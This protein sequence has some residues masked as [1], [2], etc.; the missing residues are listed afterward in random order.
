MFKDRKDAGIQL[1]E[2]LRKYL[3]KEP[4]LFAIPNGGLGVAYQASKLLNLPLQC[5]VVRKLP[6]PDNPEAGFGAVAE[7]GSIYMNE[8]YSAVLESDMVEEIKDEQKKVIEQKIVKLRNGEQLPAISDRT[9]ILIDDGLAM[10]STMR[11]AI[12]CCRRKNAREVIVAVP[13]SSK[14]VKEEIGS[15]VDHIIVLETPES[16][17]AVAQIYQY[18][19]DISD[20]E[21]LELLNQ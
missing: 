15:I 13:V 10:G 6:F 11:A 18:W 4:I 3:D 9:V 1:A 16:F 12:M 14:Q 20:E 21:A 2:K 8:Y 7:D 17:R 19:Y 5:I